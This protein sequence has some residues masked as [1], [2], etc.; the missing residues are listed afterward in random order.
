MSNNNRQIPNPSPADLVTFTVKVNGE[1]IKDTYLVSKLV[2]DSAVNKIS[3]AWLVLSDGDVALETFPASNT[4]DFV[5]GNE[6]EILCGYDSNENTIFKGIILKHSIKIKQGKGPTLEL[7]C[8]SKTYKMALIRRNRIFSDKADSDIIEEIAGAN[9]LSVT[10]VDSTSVTHKTMIQHQTLDWDFVVNRAERNGLLVFDNEEG[11]KVGK[12]EIKAKD[13]ADLSIIYGSTI[14][15]FEAEMDARQQ[16]KS[17]DAKTW[18][19]GDQK[20]V[21][22]EA[23]VEVIEQ[24]G[25][26]SADQ[27]TAATGIEKMDLLNTGQLTEEEITE[28]AD[29]VL[30]RSRMAKIRGR[31][32]FQGYSNI[33]IG[34]TVAFD[35]VGDRFNGPAFVSAVRHEVQ[36]GNW[37]TQLGFGLH[38]EPH[39]ERYDISPT[40]SSGLLTAVEGLHIGLVAELEGDPDGEQRI[41]ILLPMVD[42]A[43]EGVWARVSSPD[44]GNERAFFFRPEIN[45]EVVVGFLNNDPRN[46]IVLGGL[47]SSAMP[48]PFEQ[49]DDNHEKGI[50]T[51]SEMKLVFNDEKKSL[52][53]ETPKGKIVT[54][55]EDADIIQLEDDKGNIILM[56]KEGV[57][58]ESSKDFI[59]KAMGDI[60]MEGINVSIKASA[61]LKA[62]GG[63]GAELKAGGN[64]VIKGAIVQI[65]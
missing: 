38:Q 20:E 47:H 10:S 40:P 27:L 52:V 13:S 25:N 28:W 64:T 14:M 18:S 61:Q 12:P 22:V 11:I 42:P 2:V 24:Q 49:T 29:S 8:K 48:P 4:A 58:I 7:E 19:A 23:S 45:D 31:V 44:A 65:N 53:I 17:V 51:R 34:G 62:E 41:R 35:G 3:T 1:K 5:P 60:K 50:I 30:L 16:L 15:E 39:V 6:I 54:I 9:N 63:A 46:P 43:G 33:K 55:D 26:F 21:K 57:S 37:L 59:V 36:G 56:D 32:N